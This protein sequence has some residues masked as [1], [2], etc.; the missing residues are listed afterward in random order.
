[1]AF[2]SGPSVAL[3][4]QLTD[5][6]G[7]LDANEILAFVVTDTGGV[8][9]ILN[10]LGLKGKLYAGEKSSGIENCVV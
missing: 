5:R 10:H 6:V 8:Q 1:M 4:K 9:T 3:F 2:R 7:R